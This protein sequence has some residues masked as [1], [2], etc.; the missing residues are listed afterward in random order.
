MV[1]NVKKRKGLTLVELIASMSAIVV[2]SMAVVGL[3]MT[4]TQMYSSSQKKAMAYSNAANTQTVLSYNLRNAKD[5]NL[6]SADDTTTD[7]SGFDSCISI[8]NKNLVLTYGGKDKALS[9]NIIYLLVRVEDA[10]E[11][12]QVSYEIVLPSDTYTL[13]GGFVLN[14]VEPDSV[15]SDHKNKDYF[16]NDG[17]KIYFDK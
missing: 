6:V 2:I 17:D 13:E 4:G 9:I 10:S 15:D 16:L 7:V 1:K 14:N 8:K 12:V 11:N 3:F 5:F